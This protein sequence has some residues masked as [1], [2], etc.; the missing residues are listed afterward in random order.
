MLYFLFMRVYKYLESVCNDYIIIHYNRYKRGYD[1]EIK[2]HNAAVIISEFIR[3]CG[4]KN[5][6]LSANIIQRN[7][8]AHL[9]RLEYKRK[10]VAIN[11]IKNAYKKRKEEKNKKNSKE[12]QKKS[13]WW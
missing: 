8:R 7:Y 12:I 6:E 9:E 2:E 3:Y 5:K 1:Q 13:S 10:I 11:V 4:E